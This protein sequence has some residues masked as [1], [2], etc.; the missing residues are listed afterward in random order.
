MSR[1]KRERE[2]KKENCKY[3]P[4]LRE[5]GGKLNI[6]IEYKKSE[7]KKREKKKRELWVWAGLKERERERER[8][9]LIS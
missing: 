6:K 5:R 7:R 8:G 2:N 4:K 1:K 3:E 9:S